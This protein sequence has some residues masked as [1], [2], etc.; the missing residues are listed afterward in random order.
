MSQNHTRGYLKKYP[1]L[2][3][4]QER[5]K[6]RIPKFAFEYLEGGCNDNQNL[7]VN[8]SDIQRIELM[9]EYI[10][11]R[12]P[13]EVL[14]SLFGRKFGAPFGI[15][16]IGLQ[17]L[18]W[19]DAP[20]ILAEA[21]VSQNIPFILSTVSTASIEEISEVT[22]GEAWFQLYHPAKEEMRNDLLNRLEEAGYNVLVLLADVPTKFGYRPWDIRNGLSLPPSMSLRNLYQI[23][24]RPEWA[25]NTLKSGSPKFKTLEPYMPKGL[26]LS[27]LG[28]FMNRTFDG[29]LTES[30]I[31][32]IRQKW[33]G[34]LVVKGLVNPLD[35]EK[36][37][38]LKVDGIIVSNHGGRQLDAGESSINSLK[39]LVK[40]YAGDI[41]IMMDGGI[42]SGPDIARV[43]ASGAEF[44]F[45]GRPFM[46]GVG[47]LGRRGGDHVIALL[48]TQLDQI[49]GQLCCERIQ[50]LPGHL[51]K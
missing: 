33:N 39:R 8:H 50:D 38:N 15:S 14:T 30:R 31:A 11:D 46:Y 6:R 32:E 20:R 29:R 48:K 9:P 16:P 41:T 37:I 24:S 51:I 17:G 3:D 45:M 27:Q 25:I 22:N 10:K 23:I 18:I 49:M 21:A 1:A 42:R 44:T 12:K 35:V 47:A 28:E 36:A 43:L 40:D 19:P 5:T 34:K 2:S 7:A 26:D 4:L 13:I